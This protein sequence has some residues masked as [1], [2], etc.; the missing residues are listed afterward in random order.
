MSVR[1]AVVVGLLTA[2]G[3]V[4]AGVAGAVVGITNLDVPAGLAVRSAVAAAV[5][6][7]VPYL[8]VRARVL[9]E[10]RPHLLVGGVVGLL[11]GY[12]LNP[13]GWE[14]RAFAAQFAMEPGAVTTALDLVLWLVVG[15][16]V[17]LLA[18]RSAVPRH[19]PV[20]YGA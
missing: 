13:F 12:A 20:G 16:A 19:E 8:V 15:G 18:A 11:V 10:N 6:V 3:G 14:G 9:K 5:L 4:A 7:A 2:V 17:T 1:V